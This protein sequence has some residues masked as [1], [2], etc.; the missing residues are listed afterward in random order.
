MSLDTKVI[1]LSKK[2]R[3]LAV[4]ILKES[5]RIP[6]DYVDRDP[7]EGGDP[8]CGLSNHEGPRLE[9]MMKKMIEINAVESAD[10]V[11]FDEFGNLVWHVEDKNDGV[12]KAD[13]TVIYFD[14]HTDTV[15]ALRDQWAGSVGEGVDAYDGLTDIE[16][17]SYD[18]LKNNLGHIAPKDEWEHL[19]FGRGTAD[20][21]AGVV[22][23]I[24]A[25]KILLELRDEGALHGIEIWSYG[26]AAEEDNDGGGP[27][28]VVRNEWPV[29]GPE[30]IP[31][32]IIFTEGTG[33]SDE[34]ACGIYRGQRGRMQIEVNIKGKSAHGSMPWMGLNPLEYAGSIIAEAAERYEKRDGFLDHPFLGHGTRT[35]SWATLDSP[36]D[37]AVPERFVFRFDRRLTVGESPDQA[38]RDIDELP[39]VAR[40]REAGLDVVVEVPRYTDKTW[41][42][43]DT[44]NKQIYMGWITPEDHPAITA[45]V[46]VYNSVVTP[47]IEEMP[48]TKGLLLKKEPR[49]SR[50]VFSTDGVG[51]PIPKD[52]TSVTVG[53]EKKWVISGDFKHPAMF[54]FGAGIEQNTH[55]IGEHADMR[56]LQVS[57]SMLA[58]FP[59]NYRKATRG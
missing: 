28:H 44:G 10:D 55:K 37:C 8:L 5:V 7:A 24:V 26:T 21:L 41:K 46:D 45:A 17:V 43:T 14:G 40:A 27:M 49:V 38:V 51:I 25:T 16:K 42:G 3:P 30:F 57:I 13:K 34:G 52:D 47:Q 22:S 58:R 6:A 4:E 33:A 59:S 23:Q 11:W 31:E 50:W 54:G 36:S 1:E 32:V 15:Q 9:Y 20:Q 35:A 29:A 18:G 19:L 2:Y 56:E 48:V 53:E 39:S 12:A